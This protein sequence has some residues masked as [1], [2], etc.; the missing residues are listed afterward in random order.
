[1]NKNHTQH[2][3]CTVDACKYHSAGNGCSLSDIEVGQ[4]AGQAQTAKDSMCE[5]FAKRQG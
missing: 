2:I 3:K 4:S 1:M 5:S